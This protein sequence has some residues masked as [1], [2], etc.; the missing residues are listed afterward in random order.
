MQ[1]T[2]EGRLIRQDIWREGK[3]LDLWSIVHLLSGMSFGIGMTVFHFGFIATSVIVFLLLTA[4]EMWEAMVGIEE[5]PQNH[6]MD[7]VVGMASF[8]PTYFLS[9]AISPAFFLLFTGVFILN[10]TLAVL[11]WLESRK[12]AALEARIRR[13]F[14]RRREKFLERRRRMLLMQGQAVGNAVRPHEGIE[15]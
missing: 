4:Y 6:F 1:F 9:P 12:A 10:V 14:L 2:R 7:V 13:R 3:W 5:T 11:G 8:I 15:V